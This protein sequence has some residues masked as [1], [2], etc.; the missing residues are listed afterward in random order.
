MRSKEIL[1]L[2]GILCLITFAVALVL[3]LGNMATAER[4]ELL[5]IE[6]QNKAREAVMPNAAYFEEIAL[7]EQE[8][9]QYR[10]L[11]EIYVAMQGEDIVGYAIGVSP[12]GFNGPIEMVV[13]I[14]MLGMVTGIN[15]VRH[16]ET[17][18]LGSKILEENFKN[19]YRQKTNAPL[20][21][22]KSG[23]PKADEI[24][25]ISG[26]TI[27]S[28]AVNDGVNLAVEVFNKWLTK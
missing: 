26:A 17:P 6:A 24:A 1:R 18:G 22:I 19:Q 23:E 16:Q 27:S 10:T 12:G 2:G 8:K 15:I 4:I 28:E 11:S 3:A 7:S 5:N 9:N 13:G 25:A 14:D 20:R 21:M